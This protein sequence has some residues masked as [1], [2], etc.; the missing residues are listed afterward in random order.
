MVQTKLSEFINENNINKLEE[1]Q[2]E[3]N[4]K[5]GGYLKKRKR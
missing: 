2:V 1:E 3:I 5:Y 4:I